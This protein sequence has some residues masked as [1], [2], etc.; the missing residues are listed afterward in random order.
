MASARD[1]GGAIP[2]GGGGCRAPIAPVASNGGAFGGG[3][4]FDKGGTNDW[5]TLPPEGRL[6]L[7]LW[8]ARL[9]QHK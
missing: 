5:A 2:G 6:S 8:E 7:A 1:E 3:G 9:E 4:S